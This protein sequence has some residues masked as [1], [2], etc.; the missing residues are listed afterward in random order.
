MGHLFPKRAL[1]QMIKNHYDNGLLLLE[2]AYQNGK[3]VD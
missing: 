1:A 2:T 3:I